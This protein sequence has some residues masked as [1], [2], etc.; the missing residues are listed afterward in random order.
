[1]WNGWFV[2]KFVV[3]I[4]FWLLVYL[5]ICGMMSLDCFFGMMVSFIW[6]NICLSCLVEVFWVV[7]KDVVVW[8]LL[9][10][11]R[12]L[13][14]VSWRFRFVFFMLIVFVVVL[15]L[16]LY[17]KNICGLLWMVFW[18]FLFILFC[19]WRKFFMLV[20]RRCGFY[21]L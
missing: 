14:L 5:E 7:C 6:I 11:C 19:V 21:F 18:I 15:R 8:L 16:L 9:M 1:M 20:F 12:L 4:L 10:I 2:K 3:F 13:V 17:E